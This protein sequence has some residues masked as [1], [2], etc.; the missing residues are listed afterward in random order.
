M[1][2]RTHAHTH[3]DDTSFIT[4]PTYHDLYPPSSLLSFP[5]LSLLLLFSREIYKLLNFFSFNAAPRHVEKRH[6]EAVLPSHCEA[7]LHADVQ[8]IMANEARNVRE[9]VHENVAGKKFRWNCRDDT[10]GTQI[11][12]QQI[13]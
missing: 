13:Y 1:C 7:S 6:V 9:N 5:S 2:T 10:I 12:C 4:H 11:Y 8:S 3:D